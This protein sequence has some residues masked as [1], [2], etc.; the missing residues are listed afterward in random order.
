[1][2]LSNFGLEHWGTLVICLV[3]RLTWLKIYFEQADTERSV[4]KK[5]KS[6]GVWLKQ[7]THDLKAGVSC[8][9]SV[10]KKSTRER[11]GT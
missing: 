8:I 6:M 4:K 9:F 11:E 1:M 7:K 5:G 3:L 10:G 2:E